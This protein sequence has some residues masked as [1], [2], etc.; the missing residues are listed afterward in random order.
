MT[1]NEQKDMIVV[2]YYI[3]N[4]N[5]NNKKNAQMLKDKIIAISVQIDSFHKFQALLFGTYLSILQ[6]IFPR[7]GIL[8]LIYRTA[9][10]CSCV[11]DVVFKRGM[12]GKIYW[13]KSHRFY[14]PRMV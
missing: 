5:I 14:T 3:D 6:G 4:L 7:V 8:Q 12:F 11:H 10:T 2:V 13:Y 1:I 9:T